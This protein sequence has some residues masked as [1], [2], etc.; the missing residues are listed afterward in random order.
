MYYHITYFSTRERELQKPSSP[1]VLT[2]KASTCC[3]SLR[4][5]MGFKCNTAKPRD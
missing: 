1:T 5:Q 3:N 2:G 4:S